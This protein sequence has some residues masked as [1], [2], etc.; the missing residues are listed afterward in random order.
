M[1][2]LTVTEFDDKEEFEQGIE[3]QHIRARIKNTLNLPVDALGKSIR[4][5]QLIPTKY[6]CA[7]AEAKDDLVTIF[8]RM[9]D[10]GSPEYEH[11]LV[12]SCTKDLQKCGTSISKSTING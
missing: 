3:F 10:L 5:L 8:R 1:A 7:R 12:R 9:L 6:V 11:Q 2:K 4:V